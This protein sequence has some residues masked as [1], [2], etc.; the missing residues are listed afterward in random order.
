MIPQ[1]QLNT[2]DRRYFIVH[3]ATTG[4]C[5][6]QSRNT[7]HFWYL[8]SKQPDS[9]KIYIMHSHFEGQNFHSHSNSKS[10]QSAISQIKSHDNFQLRN[11]LP[12]YHLGYSFEEINRMNE[13]VVFY[14]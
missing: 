7:L 11:R 3:A 8:Q 1:K 13:E 6:L 5:I 2:I 4:Y 14:F 9:E 10:L 12:E